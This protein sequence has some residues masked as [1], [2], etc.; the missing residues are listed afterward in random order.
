[1][2][3]NAA[4]LTVGI[5]LGG[6]QV[7]AGLAQD[8]QVLARASRPT[9]VAGGPRAIIAQFEALVA[10]VASR[11]G[12]RPLAGI[13][14]SAPGPLD[15]A[16]GV[17]L[18]IPTLPGW[19]DFPLREVMATRFGLPVI[20]ENDGLAAAFG[21]WRFGAGR[22]VDHLVYVTVSTGIGG[23][24]IADGR[25]LRGRRGMAGHVG[26][27]RLATEGPRC[28]CGTIGCFEAFA[29]GTAL[30]ERA[31]LAAARQPDGFLAA[32]A[33]NEHL[34]GRHVLAG[35][36]AGDP[37][38]LA[39]LDQEA[40]YLARGFASLVHLF[41]PEIIIMGGGVSQAFDL[42]ADRIIAQVRRDVMPAFRD[43]RIVPALL[44][45]NSGLVGAA[46]LATQ[47]GEALS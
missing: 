44:G 4:P 38:C 12:G 19:Q 45:D 27:M 24:V 22:G 23:G 31:R 40:D 32:A 14:V 16:S 29:S 43:V 6:T 18:G 25:L 10:E 9:D 33:G 34:E 20:V 39:L 1:M 17:V 46:A 2:P 5:D 37:A 11:A 21:E 13:G 7:R 30:G 47:I 42:M 28:P 36:R 35:A 8:G 41:S 3:D 15:S 26:H